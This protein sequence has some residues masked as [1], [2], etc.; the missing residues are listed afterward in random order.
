M[1]RSRLVT[2]IVLAIVG[3]VWIAQGLAL[4][5]GGPMSGSNF[6]AVVGVLLLV[7]AGV[8]LFRERRLTSR[9]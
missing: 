7:L 5:K 4:L 6:W 1:R 9:A 2:A 3:L 8:I